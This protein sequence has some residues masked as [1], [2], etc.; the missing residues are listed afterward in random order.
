V[1]NKSDLWI[2]GL[3]AGDREYRINGVTYRVSSRF[4]PFD[5]AENLKGRFERTIVSDF[6]PLTVPKAEDKIT[7]ESVCSAAGKEG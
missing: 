6:I 5:S 1:N 2:V 3:G 4:E 7:A